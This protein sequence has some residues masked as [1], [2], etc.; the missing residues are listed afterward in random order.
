MKLTFGYVLLLKLVLLILVAPIFGQTGIVKGK[1]KERDGKTLEGVLIRATN[2]KIKTLVRETKSDSKGDFEFTDLPVGDYSF[3]L[4]KKGYATFL[5]RNLT[6]AAGETLKLKNTIELKREE[7][8]YAAIRGAIF[9]GAGFSLPNAIVTIERIDGAGKFKQERVSGEG[10]E[11]AFRIKAE[12]AK[13]RVTASGKGFQ[14]AS[15]EV[16]IE[17]DEVRNVALT[18]QQVK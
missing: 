5:S 12:K 11:F 8:P 4:E 6:V 14:P 9:Y 3:S 18:L 16:E 2:I 13:Y 1:V 10:G 15:T 7:A 17:G